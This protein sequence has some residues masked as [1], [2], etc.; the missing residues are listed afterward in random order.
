MV[1]RLCFAIITERDH[2]YETH[3]PAKQFYVFLATTPTNVL[4]AGTAEIWKT[5][6]VGKV[7]LIYGKTK[8]LHHCGNYSTFLE[9]GF[10]LDVFCTSTQNVLPWQDLN[11]HRSRRD[12]NPQCLDPSSNALSYAT[13]L[14][15]R[16]SYTAGSNLML[17]DMAWSRMLQPVLLPVENTGMEGRM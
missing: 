8:A 17:K 5:K 16:L 3:S 10:V 9:K 15:Y 2:K 12:S 7:L 4:T 13:R 14:L 1:Q 11:L 6:F